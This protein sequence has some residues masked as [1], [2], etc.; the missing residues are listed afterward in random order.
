MVVST[1][2]YAPSYFMVNG[3]SFPDVVDPNYAAAYPAQP[4]NGNP[5]LHPGELVLLRV[6]GTSRWQHTLHEH[7]NHIR[8]L[9]RDGNMLLTASNKLAGPLLFTTTSTP[10]QAMDGIYQWTSK[11]LNW[12]VYAHAPGI[13]AATCSPDANGY[14]TTASGAPTTAPNYYEW[15]ADHEKA[16]ESKPFG[17]VG[18]GGPVTLPDPTIL[19]MGPWYGGSPYLGSDATARATGATPIPPSGTVGNTEGSFAFMWHSHNEREI[20]TNNAFPGGMMMMMLV[21]PWTAVIDEAN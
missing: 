4:Y 6:V 12:D 18:A 14:Y 15:C 8:V 1:E 13:T 17:R 3:R 2:P 21:D 19:A 10:G 11:G 9:A 5:H 7:G 16:L 20:T